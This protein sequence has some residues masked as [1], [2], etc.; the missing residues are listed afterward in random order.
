M[1]HLHALTTQHCD[2]FLSMHAA[3]EVLDHF[4]GRF[5]KDVTAEDIVHS[6]EHSGI[7]SDG[8]VDGVM[9]GSGRKRQNELLHTRLK[10]K[11][12]K[13]ALV[14]VCKKMIS[15]KGNPKVNKLGKDM[16]DSMQA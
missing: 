13:E 7:I 1:L 4:R 9:K 16:R 15:V 14:T 10:A 12:T 2:A 8:D 11:C 3:E 5:I 6:L